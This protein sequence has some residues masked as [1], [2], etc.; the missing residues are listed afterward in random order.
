MVSN[1]KAASTAATARPVQRFLA[2]AKSVWGWI[3]GAGALLGV[4][5]AFA[6]IPDLYAKLTEP[7]FGVKLEGTW[8]ML[9]KVTGPPGNKSVG[10]T[11]G[12]SISIKRTESQVY[13][14][15]GFKVSSNGAAARTPSTLTF[16]PFSLDDDNR[17]QAYF[18]EDMRVAGKKYKGFFDWTYANA[19][20]AG[21]YR[22]TAGGIEGESRLERSNDPN[23][24]HLVTQA[25]PA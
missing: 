15:Q 10:N 13:T 17:T 16:D 6:G 21:T 8:C 1:E 22:L 4:I 23:C 12:F 3:L 9:D 19:V 14:A 25:G 20:L 2:G 5:S 11:S 7:L 24:R 18:D